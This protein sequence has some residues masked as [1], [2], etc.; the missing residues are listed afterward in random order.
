[1]VEGLA[2]D[3]RASEDKSLS[4]GSFTKM[5]FLKLLQINGVHLTGPFKLL[6][7]ELIWICWL[8]CPLKSFPSDLMLDNLV[9]L[10]MQYSNIKE[11]W[12]EKK[13]RNMLQSFKICP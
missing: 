5:R 1:V 7:E 10:D 2:L 3:A 4:T 12:K 6:S 9:V 8:E 11:L 13:V